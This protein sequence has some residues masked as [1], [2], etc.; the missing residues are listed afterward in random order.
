M[1]LNSNPEDLVRQME[2]TPR[3]GDSRHPEFERHFFSSA[4][5]LGV[6]VVLD[7]RLRQIDDPDQLWLTVISKAT[8]AILRSQDDRYGQR[9][10]E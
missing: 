8:L 3:L 7:A 5:S 10:F 1:A 9:N 2:S 4:R 6:F